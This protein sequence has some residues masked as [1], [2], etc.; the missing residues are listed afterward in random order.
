MK[1][2]Q[3]RKKKT[4]MIKKMKRE[5]GEEREIKRKR[6]REIME[7]REGKKMQNDKR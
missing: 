6:E 5:K 7:E 1:R 3:N 4:W 2:R